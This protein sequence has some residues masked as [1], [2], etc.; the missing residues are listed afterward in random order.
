MLISWFHVFLFLPCHIREYQRLNYD[1][2]VLFTT[3]KQSAH[4]QSLYWLQYRAELIWNAAIRCTWSCFPFLSVIKIKTKIV[5]Y[6]RGSSLC[7]QLSFSFFFFFRFWR[8]P[9]AKY[10]PSGS[11]GTHIRRCCAISSAS[12]WIELV[13]TS[14]SIIF[15]ILQICY[16]KKIVISRKGR[17]KRPREKQQTPKENPSDTSNVNVETRCIMIHH[18]FC[19]YF[20]T[21]RA[22]WA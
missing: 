15:I 22:T 14:Y 2:H 5:R 20:C 19:L 4:V 1:K 8:L 17:A 6:F 11:S 21:A 3:R 7:I 9:N 18:C 10:F 13:Y 16:S 12:R